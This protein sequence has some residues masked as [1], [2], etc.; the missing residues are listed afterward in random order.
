MQYG[1]S[2]KAAPSLAELAWATRLPSAIMA[3]TQGR[4]S[5]A[6]LLSFS[7]TLILLAACEREPLREEPTTFAAESDSVLKTRFGCVDVFQLDESMGQF[8]ALV[9]KLPKASESDSDY[10]LLFY[11]KDGDFYRRHG[12]EFNLVGFSRPLFNAGGDRHVEATQTALGVR[13]IFAVTKD[14]V[15]FKPSEAPY[16]DGS[17]KGHLR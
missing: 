8:K 3:G 9:F 12:D 10:R 1:V 2:K 13:F 4:M 11:R 5:R 6:A 17:L 15:E 16:P 7:C 14:G